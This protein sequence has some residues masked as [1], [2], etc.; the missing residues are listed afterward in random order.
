MFPLSIP[1]VNVVWRIVKVVNGWG[2]VSHL[3]RVSII[4]Y[5]RDGEKLV[6]VAAKQS[7]SRKGFHYQWEKMGWD[8]VEVWIRETWKR[9]HFSPWEHSVYTWTVEGCSRVCSHQL[10]RHRIASYTQLSLRYARLGFDSKCVDHLLKSGRGSFNVGGVETV[11]ELTGNRAIIRSGDS[12]AELVVVRD[13]LAKLVSLDASPDEVN[14]A[15]VLS[16]LYDASDEAG[17]PLPGDVY[18]VEGLFKRP[19]RLIDFVYPPSFNVK[20]DVL[21]RYIVETSRAMRLYR[22]MLSRGVRGEDARMVIPMGVQTKLVVTMNAREL[23][24]SFLPLR[25]CTRAQWE[26]RSVAWL[27]WRELMK[28]HPRLFRYAGPRCVFAENSVREEPIGV[29]EIVSGVPLRMEVCPEGVPARAV[30]GCVLSAINLVEK[31]GA[32]KMIEEK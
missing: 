5:T 2:I 31:L 24:T 26:I 21:A 4:R 3:P 11:I 13:G 25:M 20:E 14:G 8:E 32:G 28:I 19:C 29:K 10:V 1:L 22:Y 6:A 30:A 16:V 17:D 15:L 12:S 7:L 23:V 18:R 9:G 27:L